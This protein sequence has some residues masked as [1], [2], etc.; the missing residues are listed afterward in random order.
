MRLTD[1]L[2]AVLLHSSNALGRASSVFPEMPLVPK[3][4]LMRDDGKKNNGGF[5]LPSYLFLEAAAA[6]AAPRCLRLDLSS[7]SHDY[8]GG[9]LRL[10]AKGRKTTPLPSSSTF[11]PLSSK[12]QYG[13]CA[14]TQ[15][16]SSAQGREELAQ[17]GQIK[18]P[19]LQGRTIRFFSQSLQV[20]A[21]LKR[22]KEGKCSGGEGAK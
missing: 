18:K 12:V 3:T 2:K 8:N 14:V 19:E 21:I 11:L 6:A 13:S 4:C 5:F 15:Y 16:S 7:T 20:V 17:K 1:N 9:A 22:E 10:V